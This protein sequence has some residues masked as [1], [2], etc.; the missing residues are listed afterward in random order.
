MVETFDA[1]G[2]YGLFFV[3]LFSGVLSTISS[4]LNG[5]TAVA[6]EDI[7]KKFII[8]D[9]SE[10]NAALLSKILCLGFGI[11]CFLLTFLAREFRTSLTVKILVQC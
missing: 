9:L 4:G 3:F 1:D 8:K 10:K 6:L 7:V 5:L 11:V 2:L